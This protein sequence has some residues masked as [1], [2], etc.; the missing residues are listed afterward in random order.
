VKKRET[1][2]VCVCEKERCN[3]VIFCLQCQS[4]QAPQ[5]AHFCSLHISRFSHQTQLS[6]DCQKAGCCNIVLLSSAHKNCTVFTGLN[7]KG[8]LMAWAWDGTVT[9]I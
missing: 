1:E 4:V 8:G 9:C 3:T 5:V 6:Y 7:G 2:C